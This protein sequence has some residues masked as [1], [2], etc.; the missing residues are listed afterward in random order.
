MKTN[1]VDKVLILFLLFTFFLFQRAIVYG[2]GFDVL[3]FEDFNYNSADFASD[4]SLFGLN[5]WWSFSGSGDDVRRAWRRNNIEDEPFAK[6]ASVV[7]RD[8]GIDLVTNESFTSGSLPPA[9]RSGFIL[10]HGVFALR[11]KFAKLPGSGSSAQE[12]RLKSDRY[13]FSNDNNNYLQSDISISYMNYQNS[14]SLSELLFYS[15]NDYDNQRYFSPAC[16]IDSDGGRELYE[17]CSQLFEGKSIIEDQWYEIIINIDTTDRMIYYSMY[18]DSLAADGSEVWVGDCSGTDHWGVPM[19]DEEGFPEFTLETI[20]GFDP[21]HSFSGAS[22]MSVDWFFYTSNSN[23]NHDSIAAQIEYLRDRNLEPINTMNENKFIVLEDQ[24]LDSLTI[25]GPDS[26][27]T[28]PGA[29]TWTYDIPFSEDIYDVEFRYKYDYYAGED[30]WKLRDSLS[31]ILQARQW[32][33]GIF[34]TVSARKAKNGFLYFD[35]LYVKVKLIAGKTSKV[36]HNLFSGPNP[37]NDY[38]NICFDLYESDFIEIEVF[39]PRGKKVQTLH[40]GMLNPGLQIFTFESCDL[41]SGVYFCRIKNSTE[42]RL[43][44]LVLVK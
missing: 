17:D 32:Y 8:Y 25:Q 19:P 9:I 38:T 1:Y 26:I 28:G 37:F 36:I 22:S 18:C 16:I 4:S 40:K 13:R 39:D 20:I 35:S 23:Y 11:C 24:L 15:S 33:R 44:R 34:M 31:L 2:Q 5:K 10:E 7:F 14:D 6:G 27:T 21:E 42:V 3:I 12:F 43:E 30:T 29:Q 41:P